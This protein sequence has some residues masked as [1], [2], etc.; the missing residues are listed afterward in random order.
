MKPRF[1]PI[2]FDLDGTL[3]NSGQDI[4]NAVNHTIVNMGLTPLPDAELL[5]YVGDGVRVLIQRS[6]TRL[7]R[8]DVDKQIEVFRA[9][10]KEHHIDN[11]YVYPGIIELLDELKG[12][13][14]GVVTNKPGHFA[15]RVV[16]GLSLDHHFATLVGGDETDLIKPHADPLLAA[17]KNMGVSPENGIMI[18]DFHND[19]GGGRAAKMT[20]CGVTWGFAGSQSVIE[21]KP[22]H[23]VSNAKELRKVIFFG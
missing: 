13:H 11:T 19:V 20:T 22:D 5:S 10:Y 4:A 16:E 8:D 14:L 6:L 3:V 15:R 7:G 17:C 23:L 9:Y 2:L 18:G 12:A 21:A 1:D